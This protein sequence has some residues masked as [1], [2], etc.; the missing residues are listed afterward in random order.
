MRDGSFVQSVVT[1]LSRMSLASTLK[2][3]DN[4]V[5]GSNLEGPYLVDQIKNGT[6]SSNHSFCRSDG[7]TLI[8]SD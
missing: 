3:Y 1:A 5:L 4:D 7:R 6:D 2:L 8:Y